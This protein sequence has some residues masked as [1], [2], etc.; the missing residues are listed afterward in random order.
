MTTKEKKGGDGK[1]KNRTHCMT[2]D[3]AG[4]STDNRNAGM[5]P[6]S[7]THNSPILANKPNCIRGKTTL[8]CES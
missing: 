3:L 6:E 2:S 4:Q 1:K 7:Y 8:E 5:Q